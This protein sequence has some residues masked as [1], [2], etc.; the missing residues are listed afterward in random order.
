MKTSVLI[1]LQTRRAKRLAEAEKAQRR[2]RG[3][4]RANQA[5]KKATSDLLRAEIKA[6]PKTSAVRNLPD[7]FEG[8][9]HG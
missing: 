8:V 2:H 5:A 1:E 6:R 7:M 4:Y 3:A 9:S